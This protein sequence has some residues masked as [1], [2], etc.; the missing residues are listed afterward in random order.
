M[1]PG[2]G[3]GT[4]NSSN[5]SFLVISSALFNLEPSELQHNT[6]GFYTNIEAGSGFY[7]PIEAYLKCDS[8]FDSILILSLFVRAVSQMLLWF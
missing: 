3:K 7:L 8:G 6:S 1:E 5:Q 4:L 2:R